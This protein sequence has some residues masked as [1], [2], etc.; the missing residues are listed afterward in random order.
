M[1][2]RFQMEL[3]FKLYLRIQVRSEFIKHGLFYYPTATAEHFE[4]I[5]WAFE[6]AILGANDATQAN[7]V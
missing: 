1:F 4:N 3:L 2:T 7:T 6:L 5:W